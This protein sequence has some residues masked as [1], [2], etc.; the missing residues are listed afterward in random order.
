MLSQAVDNAAA[1]GVPASEYTVDVAALP[2]TDAR[3]DTVERVGGLTAKIG[4]NGERLF[5]P[6]SRR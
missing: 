6:T 3:V 5:M 1:M 4:A 2:T